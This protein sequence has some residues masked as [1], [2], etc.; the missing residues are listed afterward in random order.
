MMGLFKATLTN[1]ASRIFGKLASHP[2]P[3]LVQLGINRLYTSVTGVD[4]SAF[5]PH[6][7]YP[8]LNAL[9]TREL[10]YKRDFSTDPKTIISPSD[11]FITAA[12]VIEASD[13]LQIKGFSYNIR[14]LLTTH[15]DA[16]KIERMIGG[17]FVNLYLSP[18][19]Y[20][21]YHVPM[22]MT[23]S[24]VVHVPGL[25]YPVNLKYLHKVP[26]LFV[27]N[28]RVILECYDTKDRYFYIILVG[29]LNVGK[30]T[31]SF[32]D[33]IE[34]NTDA[35]EI[36]VYD[37]EGMVLKK[38]DE[39]GMFMMGST[40]VMLFENDFVQLEDKEGRSVRY[41]EIIATKVD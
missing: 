28:E 12:G 2:F 35:R 6:S 41:G 20:H 15:F 17:K 40:V 19:D 37:Y 36:K 22:D 21:R 23:V 4:L 38:G 25:L 26:S 34:T 1:S 3:P 7:H 39:L 31:L 9:F 27:K 33:R 30:M 24:R 8:T 18:M 5:Y 11:A 29:A 10:R 14:E 16:D 32:D 13:A